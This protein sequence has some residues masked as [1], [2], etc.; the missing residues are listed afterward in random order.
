MHEHFLTYLRF[1]LA[2]WLLSGSLFPAGPENGRVLAADAPA[3]KTVLAVEGSRFTINGRPTFLL[4]ASYYGGLG[5][6][7]ER[8]AGDFD[9][10]QKHG[11]N[12]VRVWATW[13]A[14]GGDLAAV[15]P[16]TG[17]PRQPYFTSLES[18]VADCDARGMV[19]DITLSRGHVAA[20]PPRL[21][22]HEAHRRAVR[23]LVEKLKPYHNWYLDLSNERNIGDSR[24]TP[25]DELRDLR[26]L[27][28]QLD[29]SRLV[30]ASHG[31]DIGRDEL[32]KYLQI[33]SVDFITPHRPRDRASP[34]QTENKTREY[35][36][37]M[38]DLGRVVPVH[39]QEPFRRGYDDRWQPSADDFLTDLA[40]A[41][42]GGAAGWCFHNG[43]QR[44]APEGRPRRCFDLREQ[45][46]FDQL[47]KE[48]QHFFTGLSELSQP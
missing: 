21:P 33:A 18:L 46:L 43:D 31:G 41:R 20:G 13:A 4:G 26:E 44:G 36:A 6:D 10:L 24:H 5:A 27:V 11:V 29:E 23:T 2:A 30:T 37:T 22:S 32:R 45:S 19:V 1:A 42:T 47:D 7:D 8:R 39:Y 28:R 34:R 9:R 40:Q 3:A 35:L 48:E 12:W 16:A 17:E 15:E 14:F 38:R 25:F